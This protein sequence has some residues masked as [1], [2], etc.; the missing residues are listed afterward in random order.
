MA[1]MNGCTD[2]SRKMRHV[3]QSLKADL[4]VAILYDNYYLI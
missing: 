1:V 2:H 3:R 4:E